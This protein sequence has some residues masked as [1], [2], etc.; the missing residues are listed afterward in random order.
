MWTAH[1]FCEPTIGDDVV[2]PAMLPPSAASLSTRRRSLFNNVL[3]AIKT[4]QRVEKIYSGSVSVVPGK[5]T[6]L[7]QMYV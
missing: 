4:R 5:G 7:P 1:A 2:T 3:K 6:V